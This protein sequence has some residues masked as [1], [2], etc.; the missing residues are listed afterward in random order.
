VVEPG[1]RITLPNFL[2]PNMLSDNELMVESPQSTLNQSP[3]YL[4]YFCKLCPNGTL[5]ATL[6]LTLINGSKSFYTL[7]SGL[8]LRLAILVAFLGLM[9][10]S[11]RPFCRLFCPMGALYALTARVAVTRLKV[12]ATACIDCGHCDKV[13]PMDLDVRKEIGGAECIA[14]GDCKKVCPQSGIKRVVGF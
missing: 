13:C 1:Q 6:P 8:W 9:V 10:I 4:L 5:T 2:I 7:A 3:R 12:E 11:S 14:C